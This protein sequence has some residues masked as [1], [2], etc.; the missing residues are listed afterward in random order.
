MTARTKRKTK[1]VAW[2]DGEMGESP[3]LSGSWFLTV[4]LRWAHPVDSHSQL[5]RTPPTKKYFTLSLPNV[6]LDN[7]AVHRQGFAV[8]TDL[9]T[10]SPF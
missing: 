1:T 6:C 9:A 2:T 8:P 4:G 3:T 5:Q 7:R 10:A